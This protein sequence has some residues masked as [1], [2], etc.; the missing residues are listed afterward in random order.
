MRGSRR[1]CY[2]P[3]ATHNTS[4]ATCASRDK[5]RDAGFRPPYGSEIIIIVLRACTHTISNSSRF[6]GHNFMCARHYVAGIYSIPAPGR[7]GEGLGGT[8]LMVQVGC[9][10]PPPVGAAACGKRGSLLDDRSGT[11]SSSSSSGGGGD[12][13]GSS[14][15]HSNVSNVQ[16]GSGCQC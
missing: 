14:S 4:R 7:G 11:R 15:S 8:G 13:G 1:C 3:T 6:W 10:S 5:P 2:S 16:G 9:C 12:A